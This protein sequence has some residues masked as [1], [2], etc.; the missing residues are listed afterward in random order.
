[1]K[2]KEKQILEKFQEVG[3]MISNLKTQIDDNRIQINKLEFQLNNPAKYKVGDKLNNLLITSVNCEL[4]SVCPSTCPHQ[5]RKE[6][7]WIYGYTNTE[8]AETG[9]AYNFE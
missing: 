2:L 4:T 8:T 5:Y 1:M 9:E 7:K 6:L 3:N